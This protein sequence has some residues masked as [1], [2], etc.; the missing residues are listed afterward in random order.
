MG[1]QEKDEEDQ[2]DGDQE[3]IMRLLMKWMRRMTLP[4]I[5]GNCSYTMPGLA[6]RLLVIVKRIKGR[7]R[8]RRTMTRVT[9][10]ELDAEFEAL[11]P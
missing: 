7:G 6:E 9:T 5:P 2:V 4:E 10:P 11:G 8:R 1:D 3:E